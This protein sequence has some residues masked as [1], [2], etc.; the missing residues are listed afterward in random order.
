MQQATMRAPSASLEPDPGEY[1]WLSTL[2]LASSLR[3]EGSCSLALAARAAPPPPTPPPLPSSPPPPFAGPHPLAAPQSWE[4]RV[5][6][7]EPSWELLSSPCLTAYSPGW[8]QLTRC[9]R[10]FT[11]LSC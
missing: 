8:K 3:S 5:D 6:S 11:E 2:L 1:C 10:L 9:D 7:R 4:A